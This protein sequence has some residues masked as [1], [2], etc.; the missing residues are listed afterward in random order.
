MDEKANRLREGPDENEQPC[1]AHLPQSSLEAMVS[2]A[3][4]FLKDVDAARAVTIIGGRRLTGGELR[5]TGAIARACGLRLL[6]DGEGIVTLKHL[7]CGDAQKTPARNLRS[8][9]IDG[10]SASEEAGDRRW[11]RDEKNFVRPF[12]VLGRIARYRGK[13]CGKKEVSA[14]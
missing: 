12:E 14:S 1:A 13:F 9:T 2:S 10:P 8:V 7:S 5:R 4:R 6:M 3:C 11:W